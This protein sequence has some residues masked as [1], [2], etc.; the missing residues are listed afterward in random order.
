MYVCYARNIEQMI[1][2]VLYSNKFSKDLRKA[3]IKGKN[4]KLIN[5]V[6]KKLQN[7]E[8]F[9]SQYRDHS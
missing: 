4:I 8:S 1:L 9:E 2:T 7:K 3:A 6:I 5:E